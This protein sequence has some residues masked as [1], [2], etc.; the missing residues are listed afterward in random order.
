[1][2]KQ[3]DR[4]SINKPEELRKYVC[5]VYRAPE[6]LRLTVEARDESDAWSRACQAWHY[7]PGGK[8]QGRRVIP[9]EQFQAEQKA[10]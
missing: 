7:F 10:A 6:T 4:Q 9:L 2:S 1:M 3:S 5:E 8:A